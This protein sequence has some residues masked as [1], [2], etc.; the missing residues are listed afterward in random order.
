MALSDFFKRVI[1]NVRE[2]PNSGDLNRM[3][4]RMLEACKYIAA[5]VLGESF[6]SSPLLTFSQRTTAMPPLGFLGDSFKVSANGSAA[7]YGLQ[8]ASGIGYGPVWQSTATDF[9]GA[10]GVN[11]DPDSWAPVVLSANQTGI[12]VP[13]VPL[14]GHSRIDIIEVRSNYSGDD[15]TTVGIFN[16]TTEVFDPTVLNKSFEWDVRGLTGSVTSPTASTAAISY[17]IGV[18]HVGGIAG[19]TEPTVTPGYMKIARINL[20]GAVAA[21]TD[22]LIADLRRPAVPSGMLELGGTVGIPGVVGGIG[23]E[24]VQQLDLPPGVLVRVAFNS[25]TPPSAG[26]SYRARF[27]VIGG[28]LTP[29]TE[30]LVGGVNVRGAAVA[31][32]GNV[33]PRCPVIGTP[34][35]ARVTAAVASILAGTDPNY[36]VINGNVTVPLGT[37]YATFDVGIL[38]PNA[39]ALSSVEYFTFHYKLSLA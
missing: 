37:P 7:P 13:S 22:D 10:S 15:P 23:S 25:A 26:Y 27:F 12:S 14:A 8:I 1:V 30:N 33:F 9:G 29:R 11:W 21:I 38:E 31:T 39:A 19:A 4:N 3:Q 28:D 34:A 17:K 16:P 6:T 20:D 36:T 24:E 35:V 5:T 18:D 2:R 32:S